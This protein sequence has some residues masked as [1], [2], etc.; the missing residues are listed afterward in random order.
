MWWM[1]NYVYSYTIT[2]TNVDLDLG[3][4]SEILGGANEEMIP[5]LYD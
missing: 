2:T 4:F 3:D 5:L 1:S